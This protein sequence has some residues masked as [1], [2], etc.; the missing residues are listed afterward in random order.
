MRILLFAILL[1]MHAPTYGE[2][3]KNST[4]TIE[5]F[6]VGR[7][8]FF[9]FGPPFNYYEV[10][11]V[12]AKGTST[13]VKHIT[14]TPTA[15]SCF[16][17]ATVES[18][19]AI[20]NDSIS[21]ILEGEDPCAIPE[22]ELKRERKRGKHDPVFS[23][24]VMTL[25]LTCDGKKRIIRADVFDRDWFDKNTKTPNHTSWT[26]RVLAK[27][28]K[29]TG[30]TVM[31]KPMFPTLDSREK[32]VEPTLDSEVA[33]ELSSGKLD[34]IFPGNPDKPSELYRASRSAPPVP[35]AVILEGDPIKPAFVQP[36][37]YPPIARAAHIEGVV[38]IRLRV[39]AQG[40][41][42]EI[43][44]ESGHPMLKPIVLKRAEA[45]QFP[46]SAV[47][48]QIRVT[49]EFRLNCPVPTTTR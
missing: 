14:L 1:A 30:P 43:Q 15:D 12:Q 39:D 11:L 32:T 2:N 5:Q 37:E 25:G 8:T 16:Q 22:K 44:P 10:Y 18:S 42:V 4:R 41:P 31:D 47:G 35:T 7:Q 46:T 26:M 27:L 17:P 34:S 49:V 28:D 21:Q 33:E 9:D 24:A 36:L 45:W 23:G 40:L 13:S 19:V 3:P 20:L 29:V 38:V 48:Q 6:V